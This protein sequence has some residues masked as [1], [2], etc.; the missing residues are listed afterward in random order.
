MDYLYCK[1]TKNNIYTYN[2][3]T[4]KTEYLN[5]S[6]VKQGTS[7][8]DDNLKEFLELLCNKDGEIPISVGST[9]GFLSK[10]AGGKVVRYGDI[11]E[12]KILAGDLLLDNGAL[13]LFELLDASPETQG[14]VKTF[15]YLAYLYSGIDYGIKNADDLGYIFSL[16]S[17]GDF[18]GGSNEEKVWF[19]LRNAGYSEEAT[20]GVMGN[21]YQ[22]SRFDPA[23]EEYGGG[24]GIRTYW[25]DIS[26]I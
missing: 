14:L 3:S 1:Y 26:S 17:V 12:G 10:K 4:T 21:I 2:A 24:P 6:N 22:E 19:A 23:V 11:Y 7:H 20:A 8:I 13:M 25:M 5:T 16:T 9:G 15:K 18:Y